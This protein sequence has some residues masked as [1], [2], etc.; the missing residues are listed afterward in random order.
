MKTLL[1]L[2]T[3][4]LL[5][6]CGITE[7]INKNC[8]SDLRMGCNLI[9]GQKAQEKESDDNTRFEAIQKELDRLRLQ[10]TALELSDNTT[11]DDM[12]ALIARIVTLETATPVIGVVDPCPNVT[13]NSGYKEMLF[14]LNDGTVIGYFEN[15]N[16]RFLTEIKRGVSYRTTDDRACIFTL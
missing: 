1:L 13:S 3:V 6:S 4:S 12:E 11:Q 2:V 5:T 9:F 16:K 14:E 10:I 8:G 7:G 15:G